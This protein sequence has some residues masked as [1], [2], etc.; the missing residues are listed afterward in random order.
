MQL[1]YQVHLLL[2]VSVTL[3]QDS[4]FHQVGK[5]EGKL[6]EGW[7]ENGTI[8]AKSNDECKNKTEITQQDMPR[9]RV[10]YATFHRTRASVTLVASAVTL[11]SR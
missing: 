4:D 6:E 8:E 9:K 10:Y 1:F 5:C 11:L 7:D 2:L 3:S